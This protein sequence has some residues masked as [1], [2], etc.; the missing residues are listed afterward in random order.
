MSNA[1]VAC[2]SGETILES[3]SMWH[4]QLSFM[5]LLFPP[6]NVP[7]QHLHY[8]VANARGGGG[9]SSVECGR[10][11]TT[12]CPACDVPLHSKGPCFMA[13]HGQ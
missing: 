2:K 11:T 4:F 3:Q 10:R 7:K 9:G 13:Y 8:P 12:R 1:F 5:H 6:N